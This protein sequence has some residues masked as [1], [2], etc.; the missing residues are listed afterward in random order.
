[1]AGEALFRFSTSNTNLHVSIIGILSPLASVNILLS[2]NT[3]FNDSI[4]IVS[5]GPSNVIQLLNLP[6][7]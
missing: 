6:P 3:V 2:S 1:V 5:T 7:L 4:H